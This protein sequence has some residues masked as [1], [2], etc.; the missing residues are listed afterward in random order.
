M[1][2]AIRTYNLSDIL[3][4]EKRVFIES[5][6]KRGEPVQVLFSWDEWLSP[7]AMELAEHLAELQKYQPPEPAPKKPRTRRKNEPKTKRAKGKL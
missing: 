5:L 3:T 6:L 4:I 2:K 1:G 7:E